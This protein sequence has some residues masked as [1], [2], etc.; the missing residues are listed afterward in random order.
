GEPAHLDAD[1]MVTLTGF[2]WD[3]VFP[4]NRLLRKAMAH[5]F[6]Y[7]VEKPGRLHPVALDTSLIQQARSTLKTADLSTLVYSNLKLTAQSAGYQPLRLDKQLGLLGNVFRRRSGK[8]LSAPF[9]ALFT[10]AVFRQEVDGGIKKAVDQFASDDWVFG[11]MH[12]D[13]VEKAQLEQ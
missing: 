9:P 5:H 10:Q 4:R 6:K 11:K 3:R 12:I 1:Q 2:Q 13:G 8:P 7:L